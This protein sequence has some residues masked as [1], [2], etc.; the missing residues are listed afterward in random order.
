MAKTII[1]V[2][3]EKPLRDRATAAA[4]A[5]GFSSLQESIRVYLHQLANKKITLRYEEPPVQISKRAARRYDKMVKDM[6][7]GREPVYIA[8]GVD[9]LMDQL[10]GRKPP[11]RQKIS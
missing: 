3:V 5:Q 10:H 6:K 1:Q 4:R 11:V 8:H 9:D 2:P 7:S